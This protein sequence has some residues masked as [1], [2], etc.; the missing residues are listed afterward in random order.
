MCSSDLGTESGMAVRRVTAFQ[1]LFSSE[2]HHFVLAEPKINLKAIGGL[3]F[4]LWG[5]LASHAEGNGIGALRIEVRGSELAPAA[6]QAGKIF[7]RHNADFERVF[8][9]R[10]GWE[11]KRVRKKKEQYGTWFSRTATRK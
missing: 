9:N 7:A 4:H 11:L 8:G 10:A 5:W 3:K 6:P 1:G 2:S